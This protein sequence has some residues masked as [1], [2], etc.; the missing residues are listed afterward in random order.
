VRGEI[1]AQGNEV[2][3]YNEDLC[4]LAFPKGVGRYRWSLAG[5]TLHLDLIGRDPCG[6]AGV[7][8]DATY[9]RERLTGRRRCSRQ[10]P[11][12]LPRSSSTPS[13]LGCQLAPVKASA[14]CVR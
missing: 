10:R 6:R 7:L 5:E 8:N 14:V 11:P 9:R 13:S 3:L 1:V 12:S 4:G 2:D